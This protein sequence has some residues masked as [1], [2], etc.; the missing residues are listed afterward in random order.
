MIQ[1]SL[2]RE[3]EMHLVQI[4]NCKA[5]EGELTGWQADYWSEKNGFKWQVTLRLGD[6]DTDGVKAA[7]KTTVGEIEDS[8]LFYEVFTSGN[9]NSKKMQENLDKA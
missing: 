9:S 6:M 8:G 4:T 1:I 7:T 2:N 5:G 3:D